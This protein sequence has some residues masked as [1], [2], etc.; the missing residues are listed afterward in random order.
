M[1]FFAILLIVLLV[2]SILSM[3]GYT[4]WAL[5]NNERPMT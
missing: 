1:D 4:V 2:L 5:L 3:A